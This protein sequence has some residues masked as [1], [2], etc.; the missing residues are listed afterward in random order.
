MIDP[1]LAKIREE[2]ANS[3]AYHEAGHAVIAALQGLWLRTR[4]IHVD[5][6]GNGIT[7]YGHRLPGDFSNSARDQQERERTI[8]A[9]HAGRIAQVRVFPECP[10]AN[11]ATDLDVAAAVGGVL[12]GSF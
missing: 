9:L 11:W 2:Y 7:Y 3:A 10:E 1:R 4:G 6:E 5:Q 12:G 8:V